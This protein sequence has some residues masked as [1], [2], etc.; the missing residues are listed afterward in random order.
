MS[1]LMPMVFYRKSALWLC[2]FGHAHSTKL[3][4]YKSAVLFIRINLKFSANFK[5]TKVMLYDVLFLLVVALV[6]T[7]R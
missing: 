7:S 6:A 1:Y 3:F 4:S 2:F 5:S